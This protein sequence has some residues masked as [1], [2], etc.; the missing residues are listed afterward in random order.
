MEMEASHMDMHLP[1]RCRLVPL[2]VA[3]AILGLLAT[4]SPLTGAEGN[5]MLFDGA[6]FGPTAE[7]AI[8]S[9]IWDAEVSASAYQL[10]TCQLVGEPLIF[11]GP[12]PARSRNFSAQVTVECTP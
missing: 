1:D 6:A 9:A 4:P 10:F 3:S 2:T 5:R 11:P 8:Q 7:V 12:N